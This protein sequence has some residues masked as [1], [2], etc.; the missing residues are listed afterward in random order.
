MSN[1]KNKSNK[2]DMPFDIAPDINEFVTN[3]LDATNSKKIHD[4]NKLPEIL[5]PSIRD[6][7]MMRDG[8]SHFQ[9]SSIISLIRSASNLDHV[10]SNQSILEE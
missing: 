7:S 5:R 9:R 2:L 10:K 1:P 3:E 4:S 6:S 8:K